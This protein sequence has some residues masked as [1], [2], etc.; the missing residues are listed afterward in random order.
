M[1]NIGMI[2][3]VPSVI[4]HAEP[5]LEEILQTVPLVLKIPI[6]TFTRVSRRAPSGTIMVPNKYASS[7]GSRVELAVDPALMIV[8][9][10]LLDTP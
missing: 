9:H 7:V 8:A 1:V 3:N 6:S 10:A 5:A 2:L 4:L